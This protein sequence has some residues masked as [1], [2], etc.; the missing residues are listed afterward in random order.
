MPGIR[1]LVV[2]YLGDQAA[3]EGYVVAS[4]TC[5][6]D[7]VGARFVFEV[8]PGTAVIIDGSGIRQFRWSPAELS[9]RLCSF[10]YIYFA[11]PDSVFRGKS[12]HTIR[13]RMGEILARE[14]PADADIVVPVPDSGT[15]HAIG[16]ARA[17]GIPFME[18]LIKN[19]Y[20]GR[21][22]INPQERLRALGVRMKLNP[23]EEVLRGQR[24]VMVD[25]SIVRGTTSR[26]IIQLLR[27]AGAI[28]VHMRVASPPV[29]FPCF[30]GIDTAN[31]EEL[32]ASHFA[33]PEND[34][35]DLARALGADSIGY[36]SIKGMLEAFG[37]TA[38]ELCLAC[39]CGDYPIPISAQT[40]IG[41]GK[42]ILERRSPVKC[43]TEPGCAQP[44][45]AADL[46][47]ELP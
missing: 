8:S 18:G 7:I 24:V 40:R 9:E 46:D 38:N 41:L 17:S 14:A 28:E 11:R 4:E 25:D 23:L 32:I 35:S 36:L 29:L 1:P 45:V 5:A 34:Y 16:F 26:Q 10:E 44:E 39:L 30:Y 19:R 31:Q 3:P 33:N 27:D 13:Q 12:M 2:G 21:T 22:F 37:H 20:V 43:A 42:F 6:L 47:N 15:P